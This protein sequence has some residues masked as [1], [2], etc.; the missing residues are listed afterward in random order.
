MKFLFASSF[1]D[2]AVEQLV[3]AL[4]TDEANKS[5]PMVCTRPPKQASLFSADGR[6]S[7]SVHAT[8]LDFSPKVKDNLY[9]GLEN[10]D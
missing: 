8:V 6:H 3:D 7:A 1:A 2:L 9:L 4:P 5:L 10:A